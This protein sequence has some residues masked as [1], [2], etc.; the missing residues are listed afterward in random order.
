MTA[1]L[2]ST[3]VGWFISQQEALVKSY[4]NTWACILVAAFVLSPLC[5]LIW[6][7]FTS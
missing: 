7:S 4:W 2:A 6:L 5:N 1:G 3:S